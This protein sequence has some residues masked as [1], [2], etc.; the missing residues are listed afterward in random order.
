MAASNSN[1]EIWIQGCIPFEEFLYGSRLSDDDKKG[2]KDWLLVQQ[3][4]N[5]N[6]PYGAINQAATVFKVS[7]RIMS[8]IRKQMR[9][10]LQLSVWVTVTNKRRSNCWWKRIVVTY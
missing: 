5:K 4:I 6:L 9:E 8:T 7:R 3:K 10:Q 1:G 2:I